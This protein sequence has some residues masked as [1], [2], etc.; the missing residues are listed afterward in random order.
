[1]LRKSLCL[2]EFRKFSPRR[3]YSKLNIET[4]ITKPFLEKAI[5]L[6]KKNQE[7]KK[8]SAALMYLNDEKNDRHFYIIGTTHLDA[9][10]GAEIVHEVMDLVKPDSL[11]LELTYPHYWKLRSIS[12]PY[13]YLME[14]RESQPPSLLNHWFKMFYLWL[15]SRWGWKLDQLGELVV[16]TEAAEKYGCNDIVLADYANETVTNLLRDE[17]KRFHSADIN[18]DRVIKFFLKGEQ[19]VQDYYYFR[20]KGFDIERFMAN[21]MTI[22]H[23][24]DV[25]FINALRN[26]CKGKKVVGIV[27]IGHLKGIVNFW[28]R[29]SDR[30]VELNITQDQLIDP[31]NANNEF[32]DT[33]RKA[34]ESRKTK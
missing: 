1:M 9:K 23:L 16:A 6:D 3:S 29:L 14:K 15:N 8:Q 24:R 2:V 20:S 34:R 19:K 26:R 13:L 30:M 4:E 11:M 18:V 7:S 31:L 27:G 25:V 17:I 5:D 10:K 21:S 28:D 22:T 32:Y 12:L 33:L